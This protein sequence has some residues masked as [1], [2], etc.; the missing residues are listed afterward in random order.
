MTP[1]SRMLPLLPT[2]PTGRAAVTCRYRCGDQCAHDAPNTSANEYFGDVVR[3][4]VSR[5]GV[6]RAGAALGVVGALGVPATAAASPAAAGGRRDLGFTPVPPNTEDRVVTAPGY[7]ADVLIRWGDP[8]L[9][10][11]PEFDFT[12]QSAAAQAKQFGY[13]N[14]FCELAPLGRDRW[15][16]GSN[17]EYTSEPFLHLGYDEENP[18]EEQ[19]EIAWAAH[20]FSVVVVRRDSGGALR[21]TVDPHYNRRFTVDTAFELTGPAAGSSLVRTGADPKGRTVFGTFNNCS[22]GLTPWGTFLSG[23]ENIHGYFA[24]ADKVTDPEAAEQLARYGFAD[25]PSER[26]WERF[27]PRFDLARELNEANRFGY[28][29]EIDPYDPGST[30]KKHT[31]LGRLKHEGANVRVNHDGRVVAYMG[32]D[33]RFE[34]LYKFVSNGRIARGDGKGARRRNSRL[35]EDG[36]LY[37]AKF[38]G[39]SPAGQIDGS[40]KL[41]ADGEFDGTGEWLPL[42]SGDRSFVDGFTAAEVYVFTRAAAD[43]AGATRMD[44]PEDVQPSPKTGRVYAALTNNTDR[45]ASGKEGP[46]EVNPRVNNKDGHMLELAEAGGDAGA[47]RFAWRL[48]L[49][50]G[51]PAAEGTYFGGYDKSQ[52][53]PISCPDNVAFD[54]KGNLWIAT[55]G[56]ALKSNDGLF[57]VPVD[58]DRRGEVKQFLTVPIGAECCGPVIQRDRILVAVQ[59]PGERD[60]FTVENPLST[61]PDG[62]GN[63]ARPSVV[64]V[65]RGGKPIGR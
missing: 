8:V 36:T 30:P 32:D 39:D 64:N 33:E 24:N 42:A 53:S 25:G 19:V 27:D 41:P 65:H 44:R 57:G 26:K 46:T 45:G 16:M 13:N 52:V 35:L 12:N 58:G 18:T 49:V 43:A 60:G 23:E 56:N 1:G 3:S 62:P 15:L 20:G 14:D 37:V 11:A 4:A 38:S 54:S 28:I 47:R 22:G 63:L 50:C 9:P 31:A 2:H 7:T 21:A 59:H 51:D 29:V 55:D 48:L 34:Y 5:R 61:W 10:G 40:G 17:H 6:L